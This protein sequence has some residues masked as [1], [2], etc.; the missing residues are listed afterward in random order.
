[1]KITEKIKRPFRRQPPS[2]AEELAAP[3]EAERR[4]ES[5]AVLAARIEAEKLRSANQLFPPS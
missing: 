3:N 2:T 4:R 1:M 5:E